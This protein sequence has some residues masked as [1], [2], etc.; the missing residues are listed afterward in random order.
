MKVICVV[1]L[2]FLFVSCT[3]RIPENNTFNH[4]EITPEILDSDVTANTFNYGAPIVLD[5]SS[6]IMI[7]LSIGHYESRKKLNISSYKKQDLPRFWNVL[8]YNTTTEAR[9]LL[10]ED[11]IN[12]SQIHV[13]SK[14]QSQPRANQMKGKILY[15]LKDI[16]FNKDGALNSKDPTFLFSSEYDGSNLL[17]ISPKDEAL[18]YFTVSSDPDLLLIKTIR[19][20]NDNA[21][22]EKQ[23]D[24]MWYTAHF[25]QNQWVLKEIIT[26]S[27]RQKIERLYFDQWL[28][29]K[30]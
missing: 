17:R 2:F 10:T 7:P 30:K 27:N 15:E 14:D 23:D 13:K 9:T 26:P 18:Q 4:D 21:V 24:V 1:I 19:D 25:D 28:K 20:V 12:I 8:F 11:K 3:E 16:D 6:N 29:D 22:F 5:S